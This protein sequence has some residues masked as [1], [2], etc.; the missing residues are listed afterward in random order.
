MSVRDASWNSNI[1]PGTSRN[2]GFQANRG[3]TNTNPTAFSL[4][5][6]ACTA[7]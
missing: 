1:A 6:T 7:V 2:F 3:A 5:G 4:N